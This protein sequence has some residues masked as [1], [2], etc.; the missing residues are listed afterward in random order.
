MN[1]NQ[2]T[3]YFGKHKFTEEQSKFIQKVIEDQRKGAQKELLEELLTYF[4]ENNEVDIINLHI[5]VSD[6][7]YEIKNTSN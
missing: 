5:V 3:L 1:K 2:I 4:P 6:K 7:L